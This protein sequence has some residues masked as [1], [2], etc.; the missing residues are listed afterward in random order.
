MEINTNTLDS[1]SLHKSKLQGTQ[2]NLS[3]K[4]ALNS[5]LSLYF[6]KEARYFFSFFKNQI[7]IKRCLDSY[8]F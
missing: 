4:I 1:I 5:K 3:A 6:F 8:Q 2:I 7:P